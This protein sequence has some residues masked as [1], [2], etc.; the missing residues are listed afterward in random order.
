MTGAPDILE[1]TAG[2]FDVSGGVEADV[3]RGRLGNPWVFADPGISIKPW[4]SG[5]MTHAG[6]TLLKDMMRTH[7]FTAAGVARLVVRT[8]ARIAATLRH[9]APATALQA[10]FSM[11]FCL[12]V[13]LVTGDAGID[14]M[15][16][17][18]VAD[19]DIR[20]VIGRIAYQTFATEA[21]GYTNL[22][23]LIDVHL[24]DGTVHK[25]RADFARGS[26]R[27][28]MAWDDALD[29]FMGCAAHGKWDAGRAR[30]AAAMVAELETLPDVRPLVRLLAPA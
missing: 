30:D 9:P 12:A 19:P 3:I 6:L 10:K 8:N 22:T 20:A 7:G 21:P 4:P 13:M 18:M 2:W 27:A 17:G 26:N 28:P 1:A 15:T 25:G 23:T 11:P 29:K 24:A 16:D 5:S 14:V